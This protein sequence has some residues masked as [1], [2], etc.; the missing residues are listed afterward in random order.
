MG[1]K[2]IVPI[3]VPI[4]VLMNSQSELTQSKKS[5]GKDNISYKFSVTNKNSN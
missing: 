2:P 1:K 3:L 5:K 4:L